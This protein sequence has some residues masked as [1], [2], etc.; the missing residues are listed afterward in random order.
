[1]SDNEQIGEAVKRSAPNR[2]R[3]CISEEF[4][5]QFV[6]IDRE[7]AACYARFEQLSMRAADLAAGMHSRGSD[8]VP[9]VPIDN[10]DSLVIHIEEARSAADDMRKQVRADT[11]DRHLYE[12]AVK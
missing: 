9:L 2:K 6:D 5:D 4:E 1:M 12:E 11:A 8:G 10:E 7:S 3:P